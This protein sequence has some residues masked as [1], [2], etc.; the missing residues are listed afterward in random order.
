M[1][2]IQDKQRLTLSH[3]S[4]LVG[5]FY[6]KSQIANWLNRE[7]KESLSHE[8]KKISARQFMFRYSEAQKIFIDISFLLFSGLASF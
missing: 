7:K 3:R 2:R 4:L 1:Y 5:N 8:T 6:Y